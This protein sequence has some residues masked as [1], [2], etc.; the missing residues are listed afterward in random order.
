MFKLN[1]NDDPKLD[2]L[3]PKF[4]KATPYWCKMNKWGCY[5]G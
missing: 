5:F 4:A 3:S 1:K 2:P